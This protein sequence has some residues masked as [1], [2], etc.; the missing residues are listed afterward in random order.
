MSTSY[1]TNAKLAMPGLGDPSWSTP[2]N[3]N[4]AALDALNPVG[5][6]CV[7]TKEVPST[8]LNVAVAGG[9]V[10]AQDGSTVT[11]AGTSSQAIAAS[12]TKSVF[13]DGT[14]SWALTV[15]AS[16]PTTPHVKLAVVVTGSATI[17][18]VTDSRQ[19]FNVAGSWADGVNITLGTTSGS[20]IGTASTQKLGLWG[21]TPVVRPT[22][23]SATAGA[24]WTSVEQN[25][26]QVMWNLLRTIGAGS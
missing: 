8:T 1:T 24:T 16:F 21:A 7:T 14:S 20:A 9:V 3:G 6:L 26:V 11:Y 2:I 23:G 13:L 22:M 17:T 5:D 25:M 12:S 19:C 10:L 15:A 18:S 4:A